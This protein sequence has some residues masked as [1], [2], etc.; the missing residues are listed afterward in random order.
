MCQVIPSAIVH[1]RPTS[2]SNLVLR[3]AHPHPLLHPLEPTLFALTFSPMRKVRYSRS[4][5]RA[6]ISSRSSE[7]WEAQVH[8][9]AA[10]ILL[11]HRVLGT[12]S[13]SVTLEEDESVAS[14]P[15]VVQIDGDVALSNTEVL[16]ELT[17]VLGRSREWETTHLERLESVLS[18]DEVAEADG[19]T[20]ATA[21]T[22]IAAILVVA[23]AGSSATVATVV[24]T[25]ATASATATSAA[26]T[27]AVA[28]IVA[29]TTVVVAAALVLGDLLALKAI[30]LL[31]GDLDELDP[32]GADVLLIEPLVC[33]SAVVG[34]V[35][36]NDSLT[37]ELA[38][39]H[40]SNLDGVIDD[41]VSREEVD[42]IVALHG[43]W[44]SLH[45]DSEVL[46]LLLE[47]SCLSTSGRL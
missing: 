47:S 37:S 26:T 20:A 4:L 42:D 39:G 21:T 25:A 5:T 28:A 34:V 12:L 23:V 19:V 18:V 35:E 17:N 29:T 11:V 41:F 46:W 13:L 40:L 1:I 9:S 16:E 7:L 36:T 24:A 8:V 33:G 14:G 10:E 44:E 38:V 27:A 30:V 6:T 2:S 45:L 43:E 32:T 31:V 3:E 22:T 15:A